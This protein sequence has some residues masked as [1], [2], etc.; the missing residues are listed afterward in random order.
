MALKYAIE[1][2]DDVPESDRAHY[3]KQHADV[4]HTLI[5]E[6]YPDP[7]ARVAEFRANNVKLMKDLE[8]FKDVD[9]AEYVRLKAAGDGAEVV[10]L[11]LKL[12]QAESAAI[13]ASKKADH[14]AFSNTIGNAFLKAGG[15]PSAQ[16]YI[17]GEAAKAG[18]SMKDGALVST[19]FGK[20]GEP[21]T[22]N[23]WLQGQ[24]KTSDFAFKPSLGGGA[25][26]TKSKGDSRS[27][28]GRQILH[29]PSP[30]A[31]GENAAAIKAG[32][33]KVEYSN[34]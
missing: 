11:K 10:A 34:S 8:R 3:T 16:G 29:D 1:K 26:T 23:D 31:L 24:F 22:I 4:K 25:S 32:R 21:L 9:P 28:D 17:V 2:L 14:A 27:A 30:R 12:S 7:D 6:N 19:Q 20:P 33:V 13:A 18:F 5:V 15:L